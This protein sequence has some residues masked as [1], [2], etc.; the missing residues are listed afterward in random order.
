[1]IRIAVMGLGEA[2]SLYARGLAA[3]G[4]EVTG[5]DPHVDVTASGIAQR[6][7][8]ED[9]LDGAEL[10]LSLVGARASIEAARDAVARMRPGTLLADLNTSA[11]ET[12]LEVARIARESGVRIA[13]VAVLA[14]V[15]RAGHR[16]PLLASGDAARDFADRMRPLGVP[17][18][19]VSGGIGDAARR[20]LL[21]AVYMKGVAAVVI[22]ALEA[23]RPHGAEE[24]LRAQIADELGPDGRQILE[25]MLAGTYRH[26]ERREHEMRDAV[27]LLELSGS[28]ADMTRATR[29]S[30]QRILE[31]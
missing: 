15:P 20:K 13:D 17:V 9:C 11:P 10:V 18:E 3:V 2:G 6:P 25:R 28:P 29:A 23:A 22:E 14:P 4:A 8:L 31:G 24:W 1:M 21:R 30:L 27:A 26:A 16:T 19:I 5:F 12:K 7:R